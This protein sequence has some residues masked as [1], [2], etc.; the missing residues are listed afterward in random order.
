MEVMYWIV[1]GDPLELRMVDKTSAERRAYELFP[2]L[3]HE[4]KSRVLKIVE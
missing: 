3:G 4:A 1:W 2:D